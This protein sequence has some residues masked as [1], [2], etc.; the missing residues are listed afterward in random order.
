MALII[1]NTGSTTRPSNQTTSNRNLV[2]ISFPFRKENGEFP[3]K[4]VNTDAVKSDILSL[5]ATQL[6]SRPMRR[7]YGSNASE[8]VFESQGAL[9]NARLQRNI[10]Q[11]IANNEPRIT[12]VGIGI[13][14]TNTLVTATIVYVIQGVVDRVELN[15]ER[16][17]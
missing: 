11:T 4:A 14:E 15:F 9:L 5:F 3:K 12:V 17:V 2:G 8:L 6:G 16:P 7:S 13:E 10:K 1:P